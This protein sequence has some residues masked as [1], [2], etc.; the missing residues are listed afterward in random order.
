M[1]VVCS[2]ERLLHVHSACCCLQSVGGL[3]LHRCSKNTRPRRE[4]CRFLSDFTSQCSRRR[5]R[6]PSILW[7]FPLVTPSAC[8]EVNATTRE[9]TL[10]GDADERR[11][12]NS[13][14]KVPVNKTPSCVTSRRWIQTAASRP[15]APPPGVAAQV[16][17]GDQVWTELRTPVLTC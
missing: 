1:L 17:M 3:L 7:L 8:D 15:S 11:C 2:G 14:N 6:A 16:L 4:V 12:S 9:A 5:S 13:N 10:R